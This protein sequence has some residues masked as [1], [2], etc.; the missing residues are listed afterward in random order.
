M[1]IGIVARAIEAYAAMVPG[2]MVRTKSRFVRRAALIKM[3]LQSPVRPGS[4]ARN[5]RASAV[6][7]YRRSISLTSFDHHRRPLVV[8]IGGTTRAASSTVAQ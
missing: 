3:V 7:R 2:Y 5:P 8:G 1:L 4:L 6:S